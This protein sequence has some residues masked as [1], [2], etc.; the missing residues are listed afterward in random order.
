[1]RGNPPALTGDRA[2]D[3]ATLLFYLYDRDDIRGRLLDRA[4]GLRNEWALDAYLAH[5]LLS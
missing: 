4:L 3:L 5:M 1:M 2:F